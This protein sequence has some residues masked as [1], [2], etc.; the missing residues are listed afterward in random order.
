MYI[1]LTDNSQNADTGQE[2]IK[3]KKVCVCVFNTVL[4]VCLQS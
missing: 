1:L 4:L 2:E 3:S